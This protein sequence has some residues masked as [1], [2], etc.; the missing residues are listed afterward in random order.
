MT[1]SKETFLERKRNDL[2]W[3]KEPEWYMEHIW[4]S[5]QQFYGIEVRKEAFQL[6]GENPVDLESVIRYLEEQI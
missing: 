4:E 2:R 5:H 3:G 1:V 6:R